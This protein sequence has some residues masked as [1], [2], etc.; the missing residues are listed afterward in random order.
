VH[1]NQLPPTFSPHTTPKDAIDDLAFLK[2][3]HN[4][5]ILH[6]FDLVDFPR[7]LYTSLEATIGTS[8]PI[9]LVGTKLDILP[10]GVHVNTIREMVQS[11]AASKGMATII[12]THLVSSKKNIGIRTLAQAIGKL[13]TA[14]NEDVFMVGRANVGKS[15]LVNAFLRIAHADDK[16]SKVTVS[17]LPGTTVGKIDLPLSR[18]NLFG[19]TTS[20]QH[21]AWKRHEGAKLIDLPGVDYVRWEELVLDKEQLM[22]CML[23]KRPSPVTVRLKPGHAL[24]MGHLGR[25]DHL[26]NDKDHAVMVTVY[27]ALRAHMTRMSKADTYCKQL[28]SGQPCIL[29]PLRPIPLHVAHTF[30]VEGHH[31]RHAAL[32]IVV[33]GVG[34]FALNGRFPR[35]TFRIHAPTIESKHPIVWTREP[36]IRHEQRR[37]EDISRH[38]TVT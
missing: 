22:V 11:Y 35:T 27:S 7:S 12:D 1:Y 3:R 31:P 30:D 20:D 26:G 23:N 29:T 2:R 25:L 24:F 9:V 28:A 36:L 10:K 33:G 14:G 17:W 15:E 5:V 37:I 19:S 16:P 6:V 13:R 34:W 32:D 38:T 21:P 8:N 4:A 18:L